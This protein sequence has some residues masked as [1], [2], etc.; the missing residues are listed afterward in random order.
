VATG[1]ATGGAVTT[2]R[3]TGLTHDRS[4]LHPEGCT[5]V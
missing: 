1:A 2:E 3:C 5:P 4:Y